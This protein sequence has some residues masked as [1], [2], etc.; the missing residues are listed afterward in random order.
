MLR[1]VDNIFSMNTML[2][3]GANFLK[4]T[5]VLPKEDDKSVLVTLQLWDISGKI[6]AAERISRTFFVGASGVLFIYDL[7]RAWTLDEIHSWYNA[8][9]AVSPEFKS[10][11][12]GNKVDLKAQRESTPDD[13]QDIAKKIGASSLYETSAKTGA[14]VECAFIKMAELLCADFP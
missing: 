14:Q 2:T 13:A 3:L 1:Y 9:K 5:V 4:K 6:R 12:I 7:T 10:L 8:V 11:I